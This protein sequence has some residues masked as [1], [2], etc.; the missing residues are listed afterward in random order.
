MASRANAPRSEVMSAPGA[1]QIRERVLLAACGV[2]QVVAAAHDIDRA[3]WPVHLQIKAGMT[4]DQEW[5]LLRDQ[6]EARRR[7]FV[8]RRPAP[9]GPVRTSAASSDGKARS[10]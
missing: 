1:D 5:F 9:A 3:I 4:R 10:G 8:K 6:I 7:A 2:Y